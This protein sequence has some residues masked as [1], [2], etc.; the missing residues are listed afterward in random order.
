MTRTS[1]TG[2]WGVRMA[3]VAGL[4]LVALVAACSSD[5][6]SSSTTGVPTT[7]VAPTSTTEVVETTVTEPTSSA[8]ESTVPPPLEQPAIW[9]ASGVVFDDPELAAADFV[10]HVLG[11]PPVLG[12]FEAGDSRSGEIEVLSPGS[13]ATS[14]GTLLMRQLGPSSGWFIT[15]IANDVANVTLPAQGDVVPRGALTIEGTGYG[16]EASVSISVFVAGE[17]V[18]LDQVTT[19]AGTMETPGPFSVTLD[20]SVASAGQTVMVLVRGGVGLETDPG[21]LAAIAIVIG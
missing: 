8:V 17:E 6:T 5:E 18:A 19:Q 1:G 15:G 4:T 12:P 10:V 11:V 16:F 21:E 2:R 13:P 7:S 3:T 20:A 9:P 14:R